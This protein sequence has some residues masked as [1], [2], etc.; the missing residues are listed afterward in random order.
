MITRR[1]HT[2]CRRR[3]P[4]SSDGD[5]G[6]H[7][8]QCRR[9]PR[10]GRAAALRARRCAWPSCGVERAAR[11]VVEARLAGRRHRRAGR[12]AGDR[13]DRRLG[14]A[15]LPAPTAR[16][17]TVVELGLHRMRSAR[18]RAPRAA[19]RPR[20][21]G[22]PPVAVR[23]EER[24]PRSRGSRA[25]R[26]PGRP[27][28]ARA[29]GGDQRRAGPV[30]QRVAG[31][32]EPVDREH[33]AARRCRRARRR[34]APRRRGTAR[35][36]Q[37]ARRRLGVAPRSRPRL[38]GTGS[39]QHAATSS[40]SAAVEPAPSASTSSTTAPRSAPAPASRPAAPVAAALRRRAA[41]RRRRCGP[42][43]ARRCRAAGPT[44][45]ERQLGR[46][47]QRRVVDD[48]QRRLRRAV[49]L[50]ATSPPRATAAA[51]GDRP[52]RTSALVA[53]GRDRSIMRP[54]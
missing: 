18:S 28:R 4:T 23:L 31:G 43:S 34:R 35:S 37:P 40:S 45:A 32:V 9:W 36:D 44:A 53:V 16:S 33:P 10:R 20:G 1:A 21:P 5:H 29:A 19:R 25:R 47:G 2:Q 48:A 38:R 51:A 17:T 7:H 11:T 13:G 24:G 42:R 52:S 22:R 8:D 26:S 50:S 15:A 6:A 49:E 39:E 54:S 30:D 12:P 14:V 46:V 41:R 27:A 3:A